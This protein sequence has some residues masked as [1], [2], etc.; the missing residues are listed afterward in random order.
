[1][2]NMYWKENREHVKRLDETQVPAEVSVLVMRG[3]KCWNAKNRKSRSHIVA[4]EQMTP[5]VLE[6][7][8][9]VSLMFSMRVVRC[10]VSCCNETF[11]S[12]DSFDSRMFRMLCRVNSWKAR[13][14]E[15]TPHNLCLPAFD[16]VQSCP[17]PSRSLP[18]KTRCRLVPPPFCILS[19]TAHL[20]SGRSSHSSTM[21]LP[22]GSKVPRCWIQP[23]SLDDP[24]HMLQVHL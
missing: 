12:A 17:A 11:Q 13:E 16:S 23:F 4:N 18:N 14:P 3:W 6:A 7:V 21:L 24:P 15:Q 19:A 20:C 5:E 22:A 10:A 2:H 9:L 1:M 8:A